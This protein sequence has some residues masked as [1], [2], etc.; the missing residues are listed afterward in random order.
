MFMLPGVANALS[1]HAENYMSDRHRG[2]PAPQ[3]R[4]DNPGGKSAPGFDYP[5]HHANRASRDCSQPNRD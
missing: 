4:A 2:Y 1:I 3:S 5:G